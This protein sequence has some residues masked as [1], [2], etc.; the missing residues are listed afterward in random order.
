MEDQRRLSAMEV[1]VARAF[2]G[3]SQREFANLVG[4]STG[5]IANIEGGKSSPHKGTS[6]L[7]LKVV[8]VQGVMIEK[9]PDGWVWLAAQV[10]DHAA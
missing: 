6:K 8:S 2:I 7:I 4:V 3:C 9:R 1:R 10:R 5:T